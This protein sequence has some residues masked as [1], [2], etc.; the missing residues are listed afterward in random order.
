MN[1]SAEN[2]LTTTSNVLSNPDDVFTTWIKGASGVAIVLSL[3]TNFYALWL[4][5]TGGKDLVASHFFTLNL[6]VSDILYCLCAFIFYLE[7]YIPVQDFKYVLSVMSGLIYCGRPMFQCCIC[8]E[9][10]LAGIHPVLFLTY[11]HLRYK[12]NNGKLPWIRCSH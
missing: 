12:I 8:V 4:I 9:R 6:S 1:T 11:K 5:L 10:Y 7:K 3:P 2:N